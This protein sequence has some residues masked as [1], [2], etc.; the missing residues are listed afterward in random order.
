MAKTTKEFSF[1]D[2][3]K[4][5]SKI[6]GFETGSILSENTFSEVDEWIPTGTIY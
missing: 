6:N 2:L 1:L 3:D 5:L 4:E